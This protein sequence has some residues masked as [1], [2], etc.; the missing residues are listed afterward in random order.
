MDYRNNIR[1][2]LLNLDSKELK[3]RKYVKQDFHFFMGK[4]KET[5]DVLVDTDKLGQSWLSS[6]DIDYIPTEDIRNKVKPLLRK[7]ARF[8]FSKEPDLQFKPYVPQDKDKCEELRQFIDG[9]LED[10]SFWSNTLKAFLNCTVK[11][12][13]LL[14][15]EVNPSEPINIFYEDIK[16]FSYTSN[17]NTKKVETITIVKVDPTTEL[18]EV[19]KQIW[20]KYTYYMDGENCKVNIQSFKGNILDKPFIEETQD[21]KLSRLP[22]WLIINGGLLNEK[23]GESDIGDLKSPQNQYNRKISDFADALRFNMFPQTVTV[24]ATA[25]SVNKMSIAPNSLAPLVSVENKTA[26]AQKLESNFTSSEPVESFLKRIEKDMHDILSIPQQEELVNIPSAKAMKYMYNDLIA[27]CEEKWQDWENP[28]NQMIKLIIES[29]TKFNCYP[30]WKEEWNNLD[31]KIILKHNYPIPE[32]LEDKK[33]LGMSEVN[34]NLKSRKTY[35]KE[36]G[37]VEDFDGEWKEILQE[38][39]QINEVESDQFIISDNTS[40]DVNGNQ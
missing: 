26:T 4:C 36:F 27:R 2:T 22:A 3:E 34:A 1:D 11:K 18:L 21:T 32:D 13:I 6:D 14:R 29:C 8:M 37:N 24:D 19:Y 20:L 15:L 38:M 33:N 39:Q 28:I 31:F 16:D 25:D 35:I 9:I 40:G 30:N 23:F 17:S 7:Q 5:E 10:N 12:R